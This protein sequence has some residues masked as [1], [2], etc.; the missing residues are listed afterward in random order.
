MRQTSIDCYNQI[1]NSGL[2]SKRRFETYEAMVKIAPCTA[3]EVQKSIN[4]FDGGRDC[5]KRISELNKL[6]VIYD[7]GTRTCN[8]TGR[9]VVEWDLTDRL[10]VNVKSSNNT[11]KHRINK[12]LNSLRQLYKNKDSSTNEEWKAV[13]DLINSI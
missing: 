8:V 12:A 1:K 7:K 5:M 11:K 10:P 9:N 3:S 4:Y 2:L 6:G 13:A